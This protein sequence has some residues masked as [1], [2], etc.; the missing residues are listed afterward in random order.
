MARIA[1]EKGYRDGYVM[2]FQDGIDA[3]LCHSQA[4]R[5]AYDEAHYDLCG[6]VEGDLE[7]WRRRGGVAFPPPQACH[8]DVDR[9]GLRRKSSACRSS[10][11][12]RS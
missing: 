7:A 5:D 3:M 10:A 2:G 6:H 4:K 9:C 1:R 11:G 8:D 12:I